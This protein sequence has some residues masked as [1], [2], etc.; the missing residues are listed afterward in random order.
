MELRLAGW[1]EPAQ[2]HTASKLWG[3]LWK[4][5]LK[6]SVWP[7]VPAGVC[8]V[9]E[10][11]VGAGGSVRDRKSAPGMFLHPASPCERSEQMRVRDLGR[12]KAGSLATRRGSGGSKLLLTRGS[13]VRLHSMVSSRDR[14]GWPSM[15][16][17]L[18][19]KGFAFV[20]VS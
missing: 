16:P 18:V 8:A 12:K 15:L 10:R 17:D 19:S 7:L 5:S 14:P 9:T 1:K 3:P 2:S 13:S 4:S 20:M 6:S 11:A